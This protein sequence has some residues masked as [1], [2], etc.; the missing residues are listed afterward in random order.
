MGA[1]GASVEKG[2]ARKVSSPSFFAYAPLTFFI[3]DT[4]SPS[5]KYRHGD[6]SFAHSP[7]TGFVSMS[8]GGS[9]DMTAEVINKSPAL[10]R[11]SAD[12]S[13]ERDIPP[14]HGAIT[15]TG[16]TFSPHMQ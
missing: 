15:P 2:M 9:S 1:K 5:E 14:P 4:T 7:V 10:L 11:E 12:Y 6:D 8:S 13:L 3:A 16:M